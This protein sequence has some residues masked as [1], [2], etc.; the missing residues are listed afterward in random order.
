MPRQI[1]E[2]IYYDRKR[3]FQRNWVYRVL[4][5]IPRIKDRVRLK[6]GCTCALQSLPVYR[7]ALA[8]A[9]ERDNVDFGRKL[10][11]STKGKSFE[12]SRVAFRAVCLSEEKIREKRCENATNNYKQHL[13]KQK[14][15]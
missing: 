15:G 9:R 5:K 6:K 1:K 8:F 7:A 14:Y 2:L 4:F 13:T 3:I 10:R 11:K 12:D